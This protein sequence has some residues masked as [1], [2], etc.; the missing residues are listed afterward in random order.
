MGRPNPD[1][2]VSTFYPL[3]LHLMHVF[4]IQCKCSSQLA[5][6]GC[7]KEIASRLFATRP[8]LI[9]PQLCARLQVL[10]SVNNCT[11]R[12]LPRLALVE[13]GF[14]CP[15]EYLDINCSAQGGKRNHS[16]LFTLFPPP[17]PSSNCAKAQFHPKLHSLRIMCTN[18]CC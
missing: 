11:F 17:F 3:L 18:A 10:S 6:P 2:Q 8:P 1:H 16:I 14:C 4:T 7:R 13:H 15:L 9:A 12:Q 5:C